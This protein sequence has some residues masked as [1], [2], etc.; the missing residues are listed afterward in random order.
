MTNTREKAPA[1]KNGKRVD[2][3]EERGGRSGRPD[4]HAE[5]AMPAR[6]GGKKAPPFTKKKG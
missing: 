3:D 2:R 6:K 1:K 4:P 5:E